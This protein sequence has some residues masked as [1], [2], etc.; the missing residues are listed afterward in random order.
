MPDGFTFRDEDGV[1]VSDPGFECFIYEDGENLLCCE[2]Y[3]EYSIAG[4]R[5]Y[6][7]DVEICLPS[8][9]S[10]GADDFEDLSVTRTI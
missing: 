6:S 10:E 9:K 2:V 4:A 8:R 5:T 1:V 7:F 3:D